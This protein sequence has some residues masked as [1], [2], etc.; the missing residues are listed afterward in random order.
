MINVAA[1]KASV[2]Q[3]PGEVVA[4]PKAVLADIIADLEAGQRA[5]AALV[6][7]RTL[8]GVQTLRRAA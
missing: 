8:V 7:I 3:L 2:E 1:L 4:L 5:A 6:N